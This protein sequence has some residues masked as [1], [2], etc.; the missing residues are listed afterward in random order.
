MSTYILF[1]I[2]VTLGLSLSDFFFFYVFNS[3]FFTYTLL[4]TYF[5]FIAVWLLVSTLYH[6]IFLNI[7]S[8]GHLASQSP[9]ESIYMV[10]TCVSLTCILSVKVTQMGNITDGKVKLMEEYELQ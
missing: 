5:T 7:N 9:V 3:I 4:H 2:L 1:F 8:S 6:F 10:L